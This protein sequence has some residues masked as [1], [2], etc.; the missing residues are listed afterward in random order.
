MASALGRLA[1]REAALIALVIVLIALPPVC[2]A[3][4]ISFLTN[5]FRRFLIFGI[6][7]VSLDLI[8]GYGGMVS[9]GHAAYVGLGAYTVG[10]LHWS[11]GAAHL[12]TWTT[13]P[14]LS[15]LMAAGIAATAALA[16]GAISLRTSGVYFIMITLAFAQLIY[17]VFVGLKGIGGDEGL[18]FAANR[19]L[20]GFLD[21]S[22]RTTFY[23]I[24]LFLLSATLALCRGLTRSRFGLV[25][26]GCRDNE[27]RM[28]ALGY[29]TYAYRLT[30]FTIAGAIAGFAGGLFAT[31]EAFVS[32][33]L[34]HWSR[35]GEFIVMV[36][37]GGM[38]TLVGPV[39]GAIV[40][41]WLESFLPE[42]SE[43]WMLFFGPA[44]ILA[45][46]FARNGVF[47]SLQSWF[48]SNLKGRASA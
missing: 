33:S 18:R 19:Q 41:L 24:V 25:I 48:P 7:A 38:G 16:V 13:E 14:L 12:P 26:Q 40:Y 44:L 3:L 47:G 10:I 39:V 42:Y 35:S 2:N 46:L 29:E 20:L 11:V 23:Y 4:G 31:H 5:E 34:M 1:S 22:N 32:P 36:L 8:L 21:L 27:R 37:L 43:H 15:W 28:R 6:A 9:F 17:F 30:C 45:V